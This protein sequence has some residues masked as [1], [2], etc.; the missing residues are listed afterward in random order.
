[1]K[2]AVTGPESALAAQAIGAKARTLHRRLGH[3]SIQSLQ[4]LHIAT[5]GLEEPVPPLAKPCE[6]CIMAKKVRVVNR[7][8]LEK[9]IVP[10]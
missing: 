9:A 5:T 8:S 2:G 6:A 4:G 7:Q 10:L 3:L 1:M